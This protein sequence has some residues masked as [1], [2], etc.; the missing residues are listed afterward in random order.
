MATHTN[1]VISQIKLPTGV[2]YDIHDKEAIHSIGDLGLEE[3][4]KFM[5]VKA[6]VAELPASGNTPGD[7]WHVV[8][9]DQEYIWVDAFGSEAAHWEEFGSKFVVEH[10]H[11]FN[12]SVTVT[13]E[14]AGSAVSGSGSI[15]VPTVS[16]EAKY[17]KSTS[18]DDTFVKSYAGATNKL[19][20]SSVTSA[21]AEIDVVNDVT[22]STTSITGVSGSVIASKATAG[23]NVEVA[24]GLQGGAVTNGAAAAWNGTVDDNGLLTI[25]WT[26]NTPTAV[27][28]PTATTT[29]IASYSFED[30]TVPKA[31]SATTVV[32]D[33][34][35]DTAK[36]ATVG[37]AVTVATGALAA[38]GG[39][40]TVMTGLGT[41][42]T[43]KAL[44]GV[45]LAA[46]SAVD[47]IAVGDTVTIGTENKTVNITGT[48]AAQ[49]WTQ[50]SGT[51]SGTT[52][53]PKEA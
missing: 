44:V 51:V 50:K 52:S 46:G 6:T 41:P 13:G 43:A 49:V 34:T 16:K 11:D 23:S 39:G 19:V 5:G 30:V 18:S 21:G 48:A 42:T 7:V 37:D 8:E 1:K 28:L 38:N 2:T 35:T 3:A 12:T 22:A 9:D 32:T 17:I 45:D 20:T 31:A 26:A 4:M 25:T 10:V 24:T 33:V 14:N 15:S 47:G 53:A 27:T 40:A 29:S 36:A